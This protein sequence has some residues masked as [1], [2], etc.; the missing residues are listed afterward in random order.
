MSSSRRILRLND[1]FIMKVPAIDFPIPYIENLQELEERRHLFK[2]EHFYAL[3][4]T[5]LELEVYK[6]ATPEQRNHLAVPLHV[7]YNFR[8]VPQV[9]FASTPPLMT[10]DEASQIEEDDCL[11]NLQELLILRGLDEQKIEQQIN[12]IYDLVEDFSLCDIWENLSN[13]AL[14][15]WNELILTDYGLDEHYLK[16]YANGTSIVSAQ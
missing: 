16:E 12:E 5:F 7:S 3:Y 11:Y 15:P 13:I 2:P 14:T 6:N 10:A 4:Q 1:G 8:N 9:V